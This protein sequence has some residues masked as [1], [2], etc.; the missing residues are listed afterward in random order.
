MITSVP[1]KHRKIII[2]RQIIGSSQID[3]FMCIKW[4]IKLIHYPYLPFWIGWPIKTSY[5]NFFW[6]IYKKNYWNLFV[7][8]NK[9]SLSYRRVKSMHYPESPKVSSQTE[10][11]ALYTLQKKCLF[12]LFDFF[13]S[14]IFPCSEIKIK[15]GALLFVF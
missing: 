13:H 5:Q 7:I 4:I 6:S 3:S 12:S 2:I 9:L 14:K 10:Y 11:F 1:K 15:K 8:E